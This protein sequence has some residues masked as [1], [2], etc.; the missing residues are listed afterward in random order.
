MSVLKNVL[1]L[2]DIN[3]FHEACLWCSTVANGHSIHQLEE[4]VGVEQLDTMENVV[5]NWPRNF[6]GDQVQNCCYLLD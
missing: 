5:Q 2:K 3:G 1:S 4:V 6:P